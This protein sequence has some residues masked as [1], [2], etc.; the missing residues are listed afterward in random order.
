MVKEQPTFGGTIRFK[1]IMDIMN[2]HLDNLSS[3]VVKMIQDGIRALTQDDESLFIEIKTDL[4][5][6]HKICY[7]LEDS[8][9]SSIALHQPFARDLR[10][11]LSTLKITNEIHRSAHDAVHIAHSTTFI[12]LELHSKMIEKIA[13]L[14]NKASSMF[15]DSVEAFR[16][17]KALDIKVWTQLDNDVDNLHSIIIE[18]V[19]D[20]MRSDSSWARAGTSLVLATRYIERIADHACN[21]VEESIYVVTSKR[22]K[23]E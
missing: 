10:F 23:I 6:V 7:L 21:I 16:K 22:V 17:R 14:A 20:L 5:K 9:S 19:V 8:I 1:E 18:E 15:K 4:E 12:D 11:I 3:L 2:A 13:E